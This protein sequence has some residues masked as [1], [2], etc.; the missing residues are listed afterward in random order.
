MSPT[1]SSAHL[2]SLEDIL[3]R[4]PTTVSPET[5]L[6][7][8]LTQMHRLTGSY[9]ELGT[10][11][12]SNPPHWPPGK[13]SYI[14]VTEGEKLVGVL[15]ERDV[16][17]LTAFGRDLA[18]L[19]VADAMTRNPR[20]LKDT[21][22]KDI[23][24]VISL[25]GQHRIRHLP[26][27][28]ARGQ[29][30]GTITNETLER[31]LQPAHLLRMR[32]VAEVMTAEVVSAPPTTTVLDIARMMAR[33]R[34]SCV[35]I[36]EPR[37]EASAVPV[38]I[39]TE[40][41]IV[42]YQLLGLNL[43]ELPASE[44]TIAPLYCVAPENTLLTAR[45]QMQRLRVRRLVVTAGDGSL[46]GIITQ[47]TLLKTLSPIELYATIQVLQK[48]VSQ[49]QA[50]KVEVLKKSNSELSELNRQ[51]QF[52][53][54]TVDNAVVPIYWV[55]SEGK[56][57]YV[58]EAARASLGYEREELL[59]MGVLDID[60]NLTASGWRGIWQ[61]LKKQK[62]FRVEVF[63][64]R[65]DGSIFPVEISCNYLEFQG[66]EYS[67]SFGRDLSDRYQAQL[68][69]LQ[70][71]EELELRVRE[72]TEE[73][74]QANYR[75]QA[76]IR[77]RQQVEVALRDSEERFR[78]VF[79]QA[80]VGMDLCDLE[81]RFI[82]GNQK[83]CDIFGYSWEELQG[84]TF[85]DLTHPDDRPSNKLLVLKLLAGEISTFSVEKRYIHKQG[86][87]I[88]ANTTASLLRDRTG[89]PQYYIGVVRDIGDRKRAELA[90]QQSEEMFRAIFEQAAVGIAGADRWGKLIFVNQKFCEIVGYSQEE[91]KEL[92]YEDLTHP[93][94][95]ETECKI[96]GGLEVAGNLS[97]SLEKRYIRKNGEIIWVKLAATLLEN[98]REPI[99]GIAVVEDINDRKLIE[100]ELRGSREKYKTLFEILP[101]GV[102][103]ADKEGNILQTNSASAKMLGRSLTQEKP[104][105]I[106]DLESKIIRQESSIMPD[107]EFACLK[108]LRDNLVVKDRE[109]GITQA[110]GK[111]AWIS[112][113]AA[114]IPLENYGVAIAYIDITERKQI[115]Q[116]KEDFLAIASHELRTPLTSLR[117]S[118]GLLATGKLGSLSDLGNCLLEFALLDTERLVR[119]V[120][121]ILDLQS[122]KSGNKSL[123]VRNC[124]T[125][126]LLERAVN[127]VKPIA[128][129]AGVNLSA[130]AV[131]IPLV[132]DGDALIQVLTNLLD[133]AIKFSDK[134][135][136]VWAL[137]QKHPE[138][139]LFA[140]KDSGRGIPADKLE[141]IFQPFGQADASDSRDR[142]GTGLGLPIC[143]TIVEQHGGRIWVESTPG[144]GSSFY[145]LLIDKQ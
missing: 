90:L 5:S 105:N 28:N 18:G 86:H 88:W 17:C 32:T 49:L 124:H 26:V 59:S 44:V 143:R 138:G 140:I 29:L 23:F 135:S 125:D 58:N 82:R 122:F 61:E 131:S 80:A 20:A 27:V 128:E 4:S 56:F 10:T 42:R 72:R 33:H 6:I 75:L 142:G 64:Q 66:K 62:S 70:L 133:N 7:E 145:V 48:Q 11:T 45:E 103:I 94:D 46:A 74:Q 51:L 41:D 101:I 69:L 30:Q 8:A 104:Q 85:M 106:R 114:P 107:T 108:A 102:A 52:T 109:Y 37:S 87:L 65:K 79:E 47:T 137:W 111:I 77:E 141:T 100:Q 24:G 19:T 67:C 22:Y 112:I 63:H 68:A 39:V 123:I 12:S 1:N 144:I 13:S 25:L 38:G 93:E 34:V 116:M 9:C 81:G 120:K 115:E 110:D 129:K 121:D 60:P 127:I 95:L 15:T 43:A 40:A 136:T 2:K 21:D 16:V 71:N 119:L 54:F 89:Q 76:E 99:E 14:L 36:V 97:Y 139:V 84:L 83:L 118:L 117:A 91:L 3:D 73:L 130:N 92:T 113:S 96:A 50:E 35:A 126:L 132:A 57:F 31:S 134:G 53:Q 55:D 98:L 78:T